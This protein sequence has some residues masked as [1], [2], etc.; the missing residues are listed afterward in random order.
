MEP[1][2]WPIRSS[3]SRYGSSAST[4]ANGSVVTV[5]SNTVSPVLL[6]TTQMAVLVED[7]SRPAQ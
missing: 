1:A 6:A 7:V 2:S 5:V 4:I 3:R